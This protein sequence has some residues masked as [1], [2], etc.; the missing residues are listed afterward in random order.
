MSHRT[1]YPET[2][3][4]GALAELL[5]VRT[6]EAEYRLE[7]LTTYCVIQSLHQTQLLPTALQCLLNMHTDMIVRKR[8]GGRLANYTATPRPSARDLGQ[9]LLLPLFSLESIATNY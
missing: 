3:A 8:Y 9:A 2:C 7:D 5:G 6:L 1:P 4:T